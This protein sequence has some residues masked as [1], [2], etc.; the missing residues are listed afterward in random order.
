LD[1]PINLAIHVKRSCSLQRMTRWWYFW[2]R[3]WQYGW[4]KI[5]LL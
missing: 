1:T 3:W 4:G 5:C 2:T